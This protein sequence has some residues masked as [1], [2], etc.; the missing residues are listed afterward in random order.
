M[1]RLAEEER[2]T[3]R[4]LASRLIII[5][6][7]DPAY[8]VGFNPLENLSDS[9]V[10]LQIA[11]FTTLLKQRWQLD[12]FGAR[13]EELL[14][15]TLHVIAANSLTLLEID[16][17]LTNQE[18]R[19]SC[20]AQL[21]QPAVRDYFEHRFDT[22][23]A[24]MQ[25]AMRD[26]I[27]NKVSVF[28]GDP[29]FRH[30]LGQQTSTFSLLSAMD[31]GFWVV[32]N[33][34]KGKLGEHA[35]TIGAM[36]LTKLKNALFA[37]KSRTLFTV[38]ADEIQNLTAIDSSIDTVLAEARKFGVS[39]CSTNQFLDQF[40]PQMRAAMLAIGTHICFQLASG[41]AEKFSTAFDGGR[42]LAE[43][44]RN[45]PKRQ[46]V[47]KS[48]HH[49]YIQ[50]TVPNVE[51]PKADPRDLEQRARRR[52]GRQRTAIEEEINARRPQASAPEEA[53]DDWE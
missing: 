18:F 21:T 14:R 7:G 11:E 16:P 13:T 53:L 35:A 45:L 22:Q 8:S 44:L 26:P 28:T 29:K 46:F 25:A 42:K 33:L 20:L 51:T 23:S 50:A 9:D 34:D 12:S 48:G 52:F 47:L 31:Q 4:D 19:K 37:R 15:N 3:G 6:P 38:Y 1:R 36:L 49:P 39:I 17:L 2:R 5:E 10:F 27:L 41:D 30:L 40:S 43:L 24:G 32:V